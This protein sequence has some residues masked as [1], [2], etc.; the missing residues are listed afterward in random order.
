MLGNNLAARLDGVRKDA[1]Y[2]RILSFFLALRASFSP[3]S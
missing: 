3:V 1:L 2:A